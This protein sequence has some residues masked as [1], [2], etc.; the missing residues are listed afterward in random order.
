MYFQTYSYALLLRTNRR[1]NKERRARRSSSLAS[2]R[3]RLKYDVVQNEKRRT[4]ETKTRK[5]AWQNNQHSWLY[6]GAFC[7]VVRNK[8]NHDQN[9]WTGE[10]TIRRKLDVVLK[11]NGTYIRGSGSGSGSGRKRQ[12]GQNFLVVWR[13]CYFV[14]SP[15]LC[16]VPS[17]SFVEERKHLWLHSFPIEAL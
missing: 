3:R 13:A 5:R 4:A 12:W 15:Q 10:K 14:C 6:C 9:F 11:G 17:A 1:G 8:K 16:S 7:C 2:N